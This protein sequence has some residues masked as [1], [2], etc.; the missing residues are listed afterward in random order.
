MAQL[1]LTFFVFSY[2]LFSNKLLPTINKVPDVGISGRKAM[3]SLGSPQLD[4]GESARISILNSPFS[5][6]IKLDFKEMLSK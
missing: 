4:I 1:T 3:A 5:D 6:S 2:F